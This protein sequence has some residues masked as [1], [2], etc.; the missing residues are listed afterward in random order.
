[1]DVQSELH[2]EK[3]NC[4][5]QH[6][7]HKLEVKRLMEKVKT[8]ENENREIQQSYE[9]IRLVYSTKESNLEMEQNHEVS[10]P[11]VELSR[12]DNS[13]R[14]RSKGLLKTIVHQNGTTEYQLEDLIVYQ[15]ANGD[16][17]QDHSGKERLT[18][19]Y[20]SHTKC[21]NVTYP[22]GDQV[23]YFEDGRREAHLCNGFVQILMKGH[24]SAYSCSCDDPTSV[25][26]I[27]ISEVSMKILHPCPQIAFPSLD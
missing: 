3:E 26:S 18:E 2:F 16:V 10:T 6:E 25:H 20:Y 22:S 8:L 1:M 7:K 21:W 19:Y 9:E 5:K 23:Y 15:Y 12:L 24:M 27:P 11:D 17:R 4:A 13:S 14:P